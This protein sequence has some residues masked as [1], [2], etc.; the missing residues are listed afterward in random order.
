[1]WVGLNALGS[2]GCS[3]ASLPAP[4]GESHGSGEYRSIPGAL[5]RPDPNSCSRLVS[6]F[7]AKPAARSDHQA[8][9]VWGVC[10]TRAGPIP[11]QALRRES[12]PRGSESGQDVSYSRIS[13]ARFACAALPPQTGGGHRLCLCSVMQRSGAE[14]KPPAEGVWRFRT[15]VDTQSSSPACKRSLSP[16]FLI[17]SRMA[18]HLHSNYRRN[19]GNRGKFA[20]VRHYPSRIARDNGSG[21]RPLGVHRDGESHH[22]PNQYGC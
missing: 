12:F 7:L 2:F 17:A 4:C 13:V 14:C 5:S 16:S 9:Q 6:P 8:R 22:R 18:R 3:T 1:M 15:C 20:I 21:L 10:G 11:R 19:C